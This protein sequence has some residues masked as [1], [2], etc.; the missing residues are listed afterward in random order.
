M[1]FRYF[2]FVKWTCDAII[3]SFF[4]SLYTSCL[5]AGRTTVQCTP[6][7]LECTLST[8]LDNTA[9]KIYIGTGFT[10]FG[11]QRCPDIKK[12][13]NMQACMQYVGIFGVAYQ[14]KYTGI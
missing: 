14:V 6:N 5:L 7:N 8:I 10:D 2:V 9:R 1:D 11:V 12:I 4:G 3:L 13:Y